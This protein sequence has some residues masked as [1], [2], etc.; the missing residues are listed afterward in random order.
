MVFHVFRCFNTFTL[1]KN[2]QVFRYLGTGTSQNSKAY[3]S[4][5]YLTLRNPGAVRTFQISLD[6][7]T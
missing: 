1:L 5:E 3:I 7:V 4:V 2:E 6:P